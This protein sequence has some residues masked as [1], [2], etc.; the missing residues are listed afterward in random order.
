MLIALVGTV[1]AVGEYRGLVALAIF[2]VGFARK[3]KREE[4]LLAGQFG[5]AFEEHK[6]LTG[7]FLPR[8]S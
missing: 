8:I 7:F 5:P 2:I 6:R 1:L 3:A 4:S